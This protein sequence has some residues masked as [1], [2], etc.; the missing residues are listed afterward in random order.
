M[1]DP[2][3][4]L[5]VD[6]AEVMARQDLYR[7]THPVRRES[8]EPVLTYDEKVEGNAIG[9][10]TVV[11]D[12]QTGQF[13]LWY[14]CHGDWLARLA[15]SEDGRNWQRKGVVL[16]DDARWSVDNL[17]L[18]AVGPDA[19]PWFADAQLAGF[20]YFSGKIGPKGLHLA[21]CRDGEHLEIHRDGILPGVGDRSSLMLDE[22]TGGYSLISRPRAGMP[23][24]RGE[25][26]KPR[27]ARMWKSRNLMDWDDRG[28]VLTYD[29]HDRHDVQIYG[30]QPFRYG[31]G[32][33]ALVEMYY[34]GMERLETQ[35]AASSD[36]IC[37]HR[38]DT[39]QPVIAMGGEGSWDSFWTVSTYNPPFDMG[40]RL[41]I[42]YSGAGT[43]H[44]SK[45]RHHR[46]VGL[47]SIRRDGWVSLESGRTEGILITTR[48][49][50][51]K[52]MKLEVNAN[53][54]SGYLAA[55][56]VS[57]EEGKQAEALDGYEGPAGRIEHV[58]SISQ[59]INWAGRDVIEPTPA[60]ACYL[61]F[62]TQQS[63]F[64][65]YRWSEA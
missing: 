23:G 21:R 13:R 55:E 29:D 36:G 47:A 14:S 60:G 56:V 6:D 11:R 65:S 40:D 7:M 5:F 12:P 42:F 20:C 58:N 37:W 59:R 15:V 30:M 2:T 24:F 33:L 34:A 39:R 41:W 38:V 63:S 16:P 18:T 62:T 35:L 45:E 31:Q 49:P 3:L 8:L 26:R 52:P 25:W 61:R 44:G 43:K 4:H 32:F 19:D 50:L 54:Y 48:L 10:A 51:S 28:I 53:C 46:A 64:F 27:V 22:V 1:Y 17:A 57:A 9:Y